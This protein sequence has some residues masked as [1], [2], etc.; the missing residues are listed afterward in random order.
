LS[1]SERGGTADNEAAHPVTVNESER[2][3]LIVETIQLFRLPT[4]LNQRIS[5]E[6]GGA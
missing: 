4:V 6:L 3:G 5:F 1:H 2:V